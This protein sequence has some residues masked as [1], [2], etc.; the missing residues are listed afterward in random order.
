MAEELRHACIRQADA[1]FNIAASL[2]T[3]RWIR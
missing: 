2:T 3:A 1:Y